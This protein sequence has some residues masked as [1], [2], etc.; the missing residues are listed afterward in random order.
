MWHLVTLHLP[1]SLCVPGISPSLS[2]ST[3]TWYFILF[4]LFTNSRCF[5]I[6]HLFPWSSWFPPS[7]SITLAPHASTLLPLS[8]SEI[9]LFAPYPYFELRVFIFTLSLFTVS[10]YLPI[11]ISLPL[12]APGISPLPYLSPSPLSLFLWGPGLPPHHL[13]K[14]PVFNQTLKLYM[15]IF[16]YDTF[17]VYR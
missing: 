11:A 3:S 15:P 12:W 14:L 5:P 8:L 9:L 10:Q 2:F 6:N 16:Y 13:H 17:L 7:F 4:S 1:H